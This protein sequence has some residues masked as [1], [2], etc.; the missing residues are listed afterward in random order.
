MPVDCTE[1]GL[2]SNVPV[3]P[4]IPR[5]PLTWRALSKNVS[6]MYFGAQRVAGEEDGL[7]VVAGLGAEVDRHGG[8]S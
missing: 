6:A 4:S 1:I 8:A 2:P 7:G 3:K 5:S